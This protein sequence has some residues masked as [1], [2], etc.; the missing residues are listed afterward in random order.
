MSR[1]FE[2]E[3]NR[4][5]SV[6]LPAIATQFCRCEVGVYD[7]Q[8]GNT[9]TPYSKFPRIIP[10]PTFPVSTLPACTPAHI[11]LKSLRCSVTPNPPC[12]STPK[13][14]GLSSCRTGLVIAGSRRLVH[15]RPAVRLQ[16]HGSKTRQSHR[17]IPE[18]LAHRKSQLQ[19]SQQS[20]TRTEESRRISAA[21]SLTNDSL[22]IGAFGVNRR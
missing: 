10:C 17:P 8:N 16:R 12:T 22:L 13:S 2:T 6:W 19:S 1:Q 11:N 20:Q 5:P 15:R 3:P 18:T 14:S 4:R 9:S 21:P 7:C